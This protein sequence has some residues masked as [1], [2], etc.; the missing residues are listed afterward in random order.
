MQL[1]KVERRQYLRF[2]AIDGAVARN[3]QD[4]SD[5]CWTTMRL[6]ASTPPCANL[7]RYMPAGR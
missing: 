2:R 4:A 6:V 1:C 3:L 7:S 5:Q